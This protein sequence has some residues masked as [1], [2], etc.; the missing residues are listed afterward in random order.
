MH[1]CIIDKKAFYDP[2]IAFLSILKI[3]A[4]K[5]ELFIISDISD[6]SSPLLVMLISSIIPLHKAEN[7]V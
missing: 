7:I 3:S 4:N 6:V 1:K 5:N 2:L